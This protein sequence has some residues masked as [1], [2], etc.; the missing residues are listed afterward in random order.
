MTGILITSPTFRAVDA[1][2]APMSGAQLVWYLTGTLTPSAVF[3][4]A[5]LATPLANP[6]VSDSAGLFPAMFRDPTVTYRTQL[7]TSLGAIVQDVDPVAGPFVNPPGS[8]IATMLLAGTAVT[9]IGYIP[10]NRAGDTAVNLALAFTALST[11][12]AGYLGAPRNEQDVA[13]TLALSDAGGMVRH[14]N[15]SAY[16]HTIPPVALAAFPIGTAIVFR[17]YGAGVL[18]IT[19]GAGVTLCIAGSGASKDVAMAQY[20]FATA[21]M[22]DTNIWVI[23]GT[24]IS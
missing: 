5:S 13:Y 22:E 2:G 10:V 19:R 6:V 15:T 12:S 7:L 20:G 1:N 3:T 9:N 24:G 18:T 21:V 11:T 17:N 16:A 8:I 14:N 4:S 23:A